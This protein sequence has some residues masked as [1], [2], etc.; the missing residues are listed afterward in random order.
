MASVNMDVWKMPSYVQATRVSA[1]N[2]DLAVCHADAKELQALGLAAHLIEVDRLHAVGAGLDTR[3]TKAEDTAVLIEGDAGIWSAWNDYAEE[4]ANATNATVMKVDDGG[5]AGQA[6]FNHVRRLRRPIVTAPKG[7]TD[8]LPND[9]VW[10]PIIGPTPLWTWS[11]VRRRADN[12][13]AVRAVVQ[14]LT[15][16]VVE[17]DLKDGAL[18]LPRNDP[19]HPGMSS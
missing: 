16:H 4:F 9:L 5:I 10:R 12:R 2:L 3:P 6:F 13:P 17:I 19:H 14:A 11:L 1:G 15:Q 8:A 7:G 18:W